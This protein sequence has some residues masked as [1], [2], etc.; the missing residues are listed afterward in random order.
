MLV[1]LAGSY[2]FFSPM[3]IQNPGPQMLACSWPK[4]PIANA[5]MLYHQH[6]TPSKNDHE[7]EAL[8]DGDDS[9]G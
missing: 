6:R 4:L 9:P 7:Q 1:N 2:Q 5:S 8:E 3:H